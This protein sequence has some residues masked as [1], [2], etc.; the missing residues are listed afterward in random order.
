M[1]V[2]HVGFL[3]EHHGLARELL[4][5]FEVAAPRERFAA[6]PAPE[7]LCEAL[8]GRGGLDASFEPLL[9][10]RVLVEREER[11]GEVAAEPHE[12]AEVARGLRGLARLARM[13]SAIGGL[14]HEP[15]LTISGAVICAG[16]CL[17]MMRMMAFKAEPELDHLA[18]IRE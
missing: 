6:R 2:Q 11:L 14:V 5:L 1:R 16:F 17:Q 10:R 7:D 3:G 18:L 9:G 8:L 13:L 12:V 4:A 15:V